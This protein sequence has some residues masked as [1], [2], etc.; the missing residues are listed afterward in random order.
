MALLAFC[1]CSDAL[2]SATVFSLRFVACGAFA[3]LSLAQ[4]FFVAISRRVI[5]ADDPLHVSDSLLE[6]PLSPTVFGYPIRA[7][8]PSKA[9]RVSFSVGG[10]WVCDWGWVSAGGLEMAKSTPMQGKRHDAMKAV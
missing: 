4:L 9:L 5:A 3:A 10:V 2:R 1:A 7:S 6:C 8:L